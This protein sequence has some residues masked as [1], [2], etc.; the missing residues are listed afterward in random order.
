[1]ESSVAGTTADRLR[2]V[3]D[4][5]MA[6]W[7]TKDADVLVAQI[8]DDL[9]YYDPAWPEI[10]RSAGDVRAFTS[11]MW[12]AV[13]DMQFSEPLGMFPNADGT[14]ACVPW[15]MSGTF[16]GRLDPPGFAPTG[17]RIELDGVDVFKLS[18]DGRIARLDTHYDQMGLARKLGIM[19]AHGSRAEKISARVQNL[20][21]R[22]R[23]R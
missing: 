6:G 12:T 10:M 9:H 18:A 7:N 15:H 4:R 14:I 23:R 16:T 5:W 3:A 13:P 17:D 11:S 20:T 22:R 21:A 19:P 2:E 1:M 8:A